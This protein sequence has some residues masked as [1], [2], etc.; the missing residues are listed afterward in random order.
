MDKK[1]ITP[2]VLEC[3][4]FTDQSNEVWQWGKYT[5]SNGTSLPII[6]FYNDIKLATI[7]IRSGSET[8]V[9]KKTITTPH[10]LETI[11]NL[12][13]FFLAKQL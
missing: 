11:Q 9:L 1:K 7:G 4:G 3:L 12:A 6:I 8:L 10:D 2:T 13:S 5:N